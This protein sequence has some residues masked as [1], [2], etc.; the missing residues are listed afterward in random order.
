MSYQESERL[1]PFEERDSLTTVIGIGLIVIDDLLSGVDEE[2][3]VIWTVFEKEDKPETGRIAGERGIIQET[4]KLGKTSTSLDDVVENGYEFVESRR[5][6]L[7]GAMAEVVG[8]DDVATVGHY[9]HHVV[10]DANMPQ[11]VALHSIGG[12][13]GRVEVVYYLGPSDH[14][15]APLSREVSSVEPMRVSDFLQE[16][17]IRGTS[18]E[19]VRFAQKNDMFFEAATQYGNGDS[20]PVFQ[21]MSPGR[22]RMTQFIRERRRDITAKG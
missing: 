15:F 9:F 22:F 4:V 5:D 14:Q 13:L 10:F 1:G 8:P 17:N 2:N 12:K 21:R 6:T 18:R 16:S 3:P 19:L 11:Q 7:L 20:V